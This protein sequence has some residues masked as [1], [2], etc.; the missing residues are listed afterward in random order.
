MT[1][2]AIGYLQR[3][4]ACVLRRCAWASSV[5]MSFMVALPPAV[6]QT[7][8]VVPDNRT[9]TQVSQRNGLATVTT[10]TTRGVNAFNSFS[11]FDVGAGQQVNLMLPDGT[12]NLINTVSG[13]RSQIDGWV[14]AYKAGRIGGNV[15][16][17]NTEGFVVGAGGVLNAGSLTLAAPSA[18]FMNQLIDAQGRIGDGALLQALT[19]TYPLSA[20][21]L[22]RIQG[23][24]N[25]ADAVT[26][27]AGQVSADAGSHLA[28][29]PSGAAQFAAL[30]NVDG[31][32][33]AAGVSTAGG[34]IRLVGSSDVSLAGEVRAAA[35]S[36]GG[37]AAQAGGDIDVSGASA[38]LLSG[39]AA[40]SLTA[41][42]KIT[43]DGALL[44]SR[45]L[46][47]ATQH[48][49][50]ASAG[51]SGA[52][53]L[54]ATQIE[55]RNGARV[56]AQGS[57]GQAGA[58]VRLTAMDDA[59]RATFG[60]LEDQTARID[61]TGSTVRGTDVLLR[62]S[63]DD[64]Y[65]FA[66]SQ[67]AQNPTPF[68]SLENTLLDFATSLRL[69]ADVTVSKAEAAINVG[70][71]SVLQAT[72]GDV[73]LRA[74]SRAEAQ[75]NVR[76]TLIGF[77]YGET[78]SR[79]SVDIG[80][81]SLLAG[82]DV[83]LKSQAD[84]NLSVEVGTTNLGNAN[85][86][87]SN[88]T[89][90]AN[91]AVAVGIA[92]QTSNVRTASN[93][94]LTA[95][96]ALSLAAGGAKS[97][98]V[99]SS[100]GSF[101][102]GM[103][104]AGVS[105]G[106]SKTHFDAQ[107][108]GTAQA[109]SVSVGA[110]LDDGSSSVQAAAGTAGKAQNVGE[111]VTSARTL[112]GSF[113]EGLTG[114]IAKIPSS[115]G[116]SGN[117][118]KF[119]LSASV[120]FADIDN[121]VRAGIAAGAQVTSRGATAATA[122]AT[123]TPI[124][125]ASAAV[126]ERDNSQPS[127]GNNADS[128]ENKSVAIS[129]AVVVADMDHVTAAT[130]GDGASVASAGALE[131]ASHA[132]LLPGW[133]PH[134]EL[135]RQ[136]RDMDWKSPSAYSNLALKLKDV[137]ANPSQG[138]TWTQNSVESE[139]LS[140]TAAVTYL[141]LD[142]QATAR[143]GAAQING[144]NSPV[145]A[146]QDV[147][148]SA[149]AEQ[150]MLHLTGVP[151]MDGTLLSSNSGSG[152]AGVGGSYLQFVMG[153]GS[154][155]SIAS[156]AS[157][158]ADDLA[159]SAR[160]DF[161]QIM[162]TETAG[163][164]GKLSINGSFSLL[165]SDLSTVAQIAAG[166]TIDAGNVLLLA[167]DDSLV[168]N[169][170]GGVARSGSIGVG[171][172]VALNEM[173]R[174]T[175]AL[176][177]NRDGETAHGGTLTARGNL[178]L[179]ARSGGTEGAF[180]LAGSGPS[181]S[182]GAGS[183]STGSP[184][185]GSGGDGTKTAGTD[186]GQQGSSGI[187]IS[188]AASVNI[189]GDHTTARVRDLSNVSVGGARPSIVLYGS[190]DSGSASALGA[191]AKLSAAN[192]TL[193]LAAAGGL[194]IA[195]G[196]TAGLA[197]AFTWN[198][199]TKDT[200]A[201]FADTRV[202]A[203]AGIAAETLNSNAS[204][205]V[206]VGANAGGKIGVAG[207]VSYSTVDN[208]SL[209]QAV[210]AQLHSDGTVR[211]QAS[212]ESSIRSV[213]GAASYG[214]KAGFGAALGLAEVDNSTA[215]EVVRGSVDAAGLDA[216]ARSANEIISV[217]AALG[218]SQGIAGS[219][220][221]TVNTIGN[222]TT[223]SARSA[224][225][226]VGSGAAS[227]SA[228]DESSILSVAGSVA[229]TTGS[230]SIGIAAAY[231]DI[232]NTTTAQ[233]QGGSV[234]GGTVTLDAREGSDIEAIAAGGSGA[235]NV[236][237]TGSLGINR[238][239]NAT[240]A[241][242]S[243]A[244]L[245]ASGG[246]NVLAS[247]SAD[248][249]SITGAASAAGTAAVGASA[250]YNEVDS[251]VTALVHG[252]T[253][254][255]ADIAIQAQRAATLDVWAIAGTAGGTAG[256]AGSIAMNL[257]G[258]STLARVDAGARVSARNNALVL[259]DSD[260]FIKSRAG[261]AAV[262]GTVGAGGAIAFN[263]ITSATAA[264]VSGAGTLLEG[265]ALGT[266]G[267]AVPDGTLTARR[268][269]EL[270]SDHPLSGRQRNELLHG[271]GVVAAS[272]AG[273]E[274]F[275]V[276]VAGGGVAGVAG[277]VTVSMM[278]GSTSARVD[279]QAR[280]NRAV[281]ADDSPPAAQ[282]A[283]SQQGLVA[284]YHHDQLFSGTGGG[285]IGA[286]AGVGGAADTALI[287]HTTTATLDHAALSGVAAARVVSGSTNEITQGVIG[288]G[289][290]LVGLAGSIGVILGQGTTQ[291]LVDH[292]E[293]DSAAGR[294]DVLA[295]SRTDT[296]VAAGAVAA[297][298][299]GV[300]ITA[301]VTLAEQQ[302]TARTV[303][304]RLDAAGTTTVGAESDFT[305]HVYG[306]TASVAGAV[307]VAGTVD[308]VVMKG[309][310]QAEI[311]SGTRVNTLRRNAAQE[312]AQDVV[313]SADDSARIDNKVG[314][315]GVGVGVG[316]S[317]A[318]DVVL[319]RSGASAGIA[320]TADVRAGRDIRVEADAQRDID[321]LSI[322]GG[323]GLTAGI[324]GAV[325]VVSVGVRPDADSNDNAAGSVAKASQLTRGSSTGNQ[326][327]GSGGA[328]AQASRAK[329][330]SARAGIDLSAD[331]AAT[332]T[333]QS[334]EAAV[335]ST[336]QLSAGRDVSVDAHTRNDINTEAVGVA[337]SAGA[338]LGGGFAV[339]LSEERT[340]AA[341][342]GTTQAGRNV[343]VQAQD[344]QAGTATQQAR[345]GGG[346]AVGLAASLALN[347]KASN[348]VAELGGSVR[349]EGSVTVTS[350]V[351]HSLE[352]RDLGAA[353]GLVGIGAA[354]GQTSDTS[355]ADARIADGASITAASL[356][357][358]GSAGSSATTDVTAA[359]GGLFGGGAGADADTDNH[360]RAS[361]TIGNDVRLALGRGSAE[362][363]ASATPRGVAVARGV[364]VSAG[365]SM[366]ISVAD[367]DIGSNASVSVGDRLQASAGSMTLQAETTRLRIGTGPQELPL[368]APNAESE[369][370]AAAGGLLLGASATEASASV[371][372][373]TQVR[374]GSGG[375]IALQ[376]G[377]A[378]RALSDVDARSDVTGL[379]VG[380]VAAGGN[381]ATTDVHSDTQALI[382]AGRL[383]AQ[384][385][386]VRSDSTDALGAA[387]TSGAGG[388]GVVLAARVDNQ[389]GANTVARLAGSVD[390]ASVDLDAA[391]T[392]RLHG[393]ADSTSASV[394]GYS[395]ANVANTVSNTT[396][397][398]LG[399]GS[400]VN[401]TA[402][403]QDA[404]SAVA[405]DS[406]GADWAVR[407]ASGGVLSGSSGGTLT[408]IDNVTST[409]VGDGARI[410]T[411]DRGA[412]QATLEIGA[413]NRLDV[414]DSVLLD[415]GGAIA[416][417]KTESFIDARRNDAQVRIGSSALLRSQ[418]D[419]NIE[420][421]TSGVVDS[422][423]QSKTYGLAGAAEGE[424][425]S[426]IFTSNGITLDGGRIE[427]DEDVRLVAGAH[428][429]L[430]ADA[431]TR[432]W[433]RTAV[434][435]P[436]APDAL[437][438][439]V[440]DNRIVIRPY[441]LPAD[442]VP[443]TD[444]REAQV[445]R[446]AIATVKDIELLAGGGQRELRGYGR[447]TDL[448]REA[449]QAL[450]QVFDSDLSLDIQAGTEVDRPGSTV[451]VDGTLFAGT[452]WRQY[453]DIGSAGQVLRQS[454]GMHFSTRDNVDVGREIDSRINALKA[455]VSTYSD[456]PTVAAG[457]QS[458]ID[459]L[460]ARRAAL[461]IGAKVG[462]I[463]LDPATAVS[464]N[465]RIT[466]GALVGA[467]SGELV[468]PGDASIR[469]NN[470][471]SRFLSVKNLPGSADC[472]AALCI[473]GDSGGEITLNGARV[474]SNADINSRNAP[475]AV[476]TLGRVD[477]RSNSPAPLIELR[478]SAD[479]T[480]PKPEIQVYGNLLNP[481][482][483][484]RIASTGS[485]TVSS[486]VTAQ[487]VDIATQGDF[488]KTFSLGYTHTA[489]DP[490]L[491]IKSL[492]DA[493][494]A[495]SKRRTP[496][497]GD[498]LTATIS[499]VTSTDTV[500][501]VAKPTGTIVAGNSVFIS[502]EK[503]NLNG[504]IQSGIA[505]VRVMIDN[506]ALA[507]AKNAQGAWVPLKN[508][509]FANLDAALR[510]RLRWNAQTQEL[511]LG[512]IQVEGGT[513]QLF[514]DILST[515]GG[516]LNVLDGY[517]RIQ[518]EN[519]TTIP[520][521]LNRL[522]TGAGTQGKVRITDTSTQDAQGR[523]LVTTI[524]RSNGQ[525]VTTQENVAT[526]DDARPVA[527]AVAADAS[528]RSATYTPRA[529]RRLNWINAENIA[530][531]YS[532]VYT[533]TCA[534]SCDFGSL[535]DWLAKNAPTQTVV[536]SPPAVYTPRIS[537]L[538][539]SNGD[540]RT[541]D[542]LY[543]FHK[544][545]YARTVTPEY[546]TRRYRSGGADFYD[547]IETRRDWGWKERNFYTH[548]LAASRPVAIR[549][550]GDDVGTLSVVSA[551]AP[552]KLGDTLR[553]LKGTT[554]L[555]AARIGLA[556]GATAGQVIADTLVLRARD[557]A[558]GEFAGS[559]VQPLEVQ[560]SSTG[561]V[562]LRAA[563]DIALRA[564]QGGLRLGRTETG[565]RL[566]LQAEGDIVRGGGATS[567]L[568]AGE[569]RLVSDNG[570]I[571]SLAAPLL[572]NLPADRGTLDA[573]AAHD[574]GIAEA[575]GDLRVRQ[576]ASS[577]GDV[578]LR[579]AQGAIV[580]VDSVQSVNAETRDAL[581][582]VA[583]R[584]GLTAD[585]GAQAGVEA[586]VRR[587][588][589]GKRQEYLAYWQ[590][591]GLTERF[592]KKGASLG[593]SARAYD[594]AFVYTVDPATAAQLK[595]AN[596]WSDA[597]LASW[598]DSQTAFYHRAAAEFGS[599]DARSYDPSWH[600]DAAAH[601]T[602]LASLRD[603]GVWTEAQI[604]QRV[605][606]GLFKDT[607]DTQILVENPNVSGRRI[608]LDARNG[609][610]RASTSID[611]SRDPRQ[612]TADQQLA[613][614]AADRAD[615]QVTPTSV[616][617]TPKD[618]LDLAMVMGA[619]GSGGAVNAKAG[620]SIYLGSEGDLRLDK[621][622]SNNG[623]VRIKARGSLTQLASGSTSVSG[624][625]VLLEAGGGALGATDAALTIATGAGGSVT[626]RSALD[627]HL[628][629]ERDLVIDQVFTPA[630]AWLSSPGALTARLASADLEVR[631]GALH[632]DA[633]TTI[634]LPG[635]ALSALDVSVTG[636]LQ[637]HAGRGAW[638]A[639]SGDALALASARVDDGPL[640]LTADGPTMRITGPV[641]AS[642]VSLQARGGDL[643]ID[644]AGRIDAGTLDLDAAGRLQ[645]LGQLSATDAADLSAGGALLLAGS[646]QLQGAATLDAGTTLD[647]RGTTKVGG[648]LA[649][650]AG[651]A[652]RQQGSLVLQSD[653][654]F[655]VLGAA[656]LGGSVSTR[657]GLSVLAGSSLSIDGLL[658]VGAA[659][660]LTAGTDWALRGVLQAQTLD[661]RAGRDLTFGGLARTTGN[662]VASA[663][664]DLRFSGIFGAG[665]SLQ[666]TAA[667]DLFVVAQKPVAAQGIT[668]V[669]GRRKV[670]P[671][672][673]P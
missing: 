197:G 73:D 636:P 145:S 578:L 22:V 621:V 514:G 185:A 598:R 629:A 614:L 47:T 467:A 348:S 517:G 650:R 376:D 9:A 529:N 653:A 408:T 153:G 108:G 367:V 346:G 450:G 544:D 208:T 667:R 23:R 561:S 326:L 292:G 204:W 161:D 190:D 288:L 665:G 655:D 608:T 83:L 192:P 491:V 283:T 28:A 393:E 526:K 230:A 224:S 640:H 396:T 434:P 564:Y 522:D 301:T 424:T 563:T 511:E 463:D 490:T 417:A 15:Y 231:N 366:G 575:T 580:D 171:F 500:A 140:L 512:N 311:G 493:E 592:D 454:E 120:A 160:T 458:D 203:A 148:V 199:L 130:I 599:G 426:R 137:A 402:Y 477:E 237:V 122:Q 295:A 566:S 664:R 628:A 339:A 232:D 403:T 29:G 39:G 487:T 359:A 603:G 465:I 445:Q 552:I 37:L 617:I 49:T 334:A 461:G 139:K 620:D 213:A 70:G 296:D 369:S 52:I 308:V 59:T 282:P 60:S 524:T 129:G 550:I 649:A 386:T 51:P 646:Q 499:P 530:V 4:Y 440:Q 156:G 245:T 8:N 478:N 637:L 144:G 127:A 98:E 400:T 299:V 12:S 26:L 545:R 419:V 159:V 286:T 373:T 31:L 562:D 174:S 593:Y 135:I 416:V 520:L 518:V 554:T 378:A 405:K 281:V 25:A 444:P 50:A 560:L 244:A 123:D 572:I 349:A 222:D 666:A 601:P 172:A 290:G 671:V 193:N 625:D 330:D 175:Q 304:S 521:V 126:D 180:A 253:L 111:A 277:T 173:D 537:G 33:S 421:A 181:G 133:Q 612:W 151:E 351:D 587:Y 618:D 268:S 45:D 482:G 597:Q 41:G 81:A 343:L 324:A 342:A 425:R 63:A 10:A 363:T 573:Q 479:G 535:A 200:Q 36:A 116:R 323:A 40:M 619:G 441:A 549:F 429:V 523:N 372:P 74:T 118:E 209:A 439:I 163:K 61:I 594:P 247:D 141:T 131:V 661:A 297:G 469:V 278:G 409:L 294:I 162:V 395:G 476:A 341:L 448:Y 276:T 257:A 470:A 371:R 90:Y 634:G 622:V 93:A 168:V 375:T 658:Q 538:W 146:A 109:G 44:S 379:N 53:E 484:V 546:Y 459:V 633:G 447:G 475:G 570:S 104:S 3:Q 184:E 466:G 320:G 240:T 100:G 178:L 84:S 615:L 347:H 557:G 668:W 198:E 516:Q 223:A 385:V 310:T 331:L 134:A 32:D 117:K 542:Y 611:I 438:A 220:A 157:V 207:S 352:A 627:L 251:T 437:A 540:K 508:T 547:N 97:F 80:Q 486:D 6:G 471:S 532:Q 588:E 401:T 20:S 551:Q 503:L 316:A 457:F 380:L 48:E 613:L 609:I 94:Q 314:G 496:A 18:A 513:M 255:A 370:I 82:R 312:S 194:S 34:R 24:I 505:D 333:R 238:I 86:N 567:A 228:R 1:A 662:A 556:G 321:A 318:V 154:D 243:G 280:V 452:H 397:A 217:A 541:A 150:G 432:L 142:N 113:I 519:T 259:G 241:Q 361:T 453:L 504:V 610:G 539:L 242:A 483:T 435:I 216:R 110:L 377:F 354:I 335:A 543:E 436:S 344:D 451:Q 182:S 600:F 128:Q 54:A 624:R 66:A 571:G 211:L 149:L 641:Q 642:S 548:S 584:A 289:G 582:G 56:L 75:M 494:E 414:Y 604:T 433:N 656:V 392:T 202:D 328:R 602:L 404:L 65:V 488:I 78:T 428:N 5:G 462:F 669:A 585:S 630:A 235:A 388:L 101:Q 480:T 183:G 362:F 368:Y 124:F 672:G 565:G 2:A 143:I 250:S 407:A 632:L 382:G 577:G 464:G 460:Q 239:G 569:I 443:A 327:G 353:L 188:A 449:L 446:A 322:A 583:R 272:T 260:D 605:A 427:S 119:G 158:R 559:Q 170:A 644:A 596:G 55:L 306:A 229:L 406:A 645:N 507:D 234:G 233:A 43:L 387:S 300:G 579:A 315:V 536:I 76:S 57:S 166:T 35:G 214:G 383:T 95:G 19:G 515:G 420:A 64:K 279:D 574:I 62:A 265:L 489:G 302:T 303:D 638:L 227:F 356:A 531:S 412:Q 648:A 325:S 79:A 206:S 317:A 191:G 657:G 165:Q 285:A 534:V 274:N 67:A 309:S 246:V 107:L 506:G 21:G 497:A 254:E 102:D 418:R 591:R 115:D 350:S 336:A 481:R 389:A 273:V 364:A 284:A 398:E 256:F 196:K 474:A 71:G 14:N 221:V 218:V 87:S 663:G 525:V 264:E 11:R 502:G 423:A 72:T 660:V 226:Q 267:V 298:A 106:L 103:A 399:A 205:S 576:V 236:G 69:F 381:R 639:V 125:R 269:T 68:Q 248:L 626:A 338:S 485:V 252:G 112:D 275:A 345:A 305:Q 431:E 195:N 422:E 358:H 164:A 225:V 390:A 643:T 595:Q 30:V 492:T 16:F 616:R 186:T 456:N 105:V 510:P 291:T 96:R 606:A 13:A 607:A 167:H 357:V 147:R 155:A 659:A 42:G 623:D 384:T 413:R 374:L 586:T 528:G 271:A 455:L 212:D 533:R 201:G 17:F 670:V 329:A 121:R 169:I 495:A 189:A 365:V 391:H 568:T 337:L 473:P 558:I 501:T 85:N 355:L 415:T 313:V 249:Q 509:A 581:L 46:G 360:V 152:K 654:R 132:T 27:A 266:T 187:G 91:A 92:E 114:L 179:D 176:L 38:Q 99:A 261:A 270:P 635:D 263:D 58:T 258:G 430:R 631:A 442:T 7:V 293:I 89:S 262:G 219:G 468:A 472:P 651:G 319:L 215:A 673:M 340:R 77:G 177:G 498:P 647:L 136:L 555:D 210:D 553:N 590:M 410:T 332:P 527:A 394:A 589:Q 88:P 411:T 138:N 287:S 652:L 307:G